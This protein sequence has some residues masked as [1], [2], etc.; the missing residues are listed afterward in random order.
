MHLTIRRHSY[1]Q[2]NTRTVGLAVYSHNLVE[3]LG[4][5]ALVYDGIVGEIS[6]LL[7]LNVHNDTVMDSAKTEA[8]RTLTSMIAAD[9]NAM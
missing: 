3:E 6:Q 4:F 1:F 2:V 5:S 8:L 7:F 9:K